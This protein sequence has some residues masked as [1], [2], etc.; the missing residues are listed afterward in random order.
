MLALAPEAPK[1]PKGWSWREDHEARLEEARKKR[2]R[3][4]RNYN[5]RRLVD[6]LE[7]YREFH[8]AGYV[9]PT[10]TFGDD[11]FAGDGRS[12]VE[13]MPL[14]PLLVQIMDD[15][16]AWASLGVLF[17]AVDEL[18]RRK[19]PLYMRLGPAYFFPNANPELPRV[20]ASEAVNG[21]VADGL[22]H[23]DYADALDYMLQNVEHYLPLHR[24]HERV[25]PDDASKGYRPK[26]PPEPLLKLKV[27]V[28]LRDRRGKKVA[29]KTRR[30]EALESY[31]EYAQDH[32]RAEAVTLAAE[33]TG[34]S[35]KEIRVIVRQDQ[36]RK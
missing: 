22:A 26:E 4:F 12:Q 8:E 13:G 20:W 35:R 16:D 30:R 19:W 9:S 10:G 33:K 34:Y 36:N 7:F 25:D 15:P 14:S 17:G 11:A 1:G 32:G 6:F 31:Y 3:S 29:V 24:R 23:Q 21:S 28:P 5:R 2:E 18:R 27:I